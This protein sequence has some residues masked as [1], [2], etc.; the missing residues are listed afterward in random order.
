MVK[1]LNKILMDFWSF[2][3]FLAKMAF[4]ENGEIRARFLCMMPRCDL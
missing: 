2:M 4:V 3:D 1:V